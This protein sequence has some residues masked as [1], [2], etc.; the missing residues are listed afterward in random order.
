MSNFR[1]N[2]TTAEKFCK[3]VEK[4]RALGLEFDEAAETISSL[5]K[6]IAKHN[7]KKVMQEAGAIKESATNEPTAENVSADTSS[8]ITAEA[9]EVSE[10]P[11]QELNEANEA[12][13]VT[14]PKAKEAETVETTPKETNIYDEEN[15][16]AARIAKTIA[17][18][19]ALTEMGETLRKIDENKRIHAYLVAP[20]AQ[21]TYTYNHKDN[22]GEVEQKIKTGEKLYPLENIL[23]KTVFENLKKALVPLGGRLELLFMARVKGN[24]IVE[25]A[26]KVDAKAKL[27]AVYTLLENRAENIKYNAN[28]YDLETMYIL[29][30]RKGNLKSDRQL[31]AT[32]AA[33]LLENIIYCLW[34][35]LVEKGYTLGMATQ[36]PPAR[37]VEAK[38]TSA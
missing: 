29:S 32:S 25:E 9:S 26:K 4:A 12:E 8:D 36:E 1:E 28:Q 37:P 22:D 33:K 3:A 30:F 7:G 15:K 5:Q 24:R 20:Y 21:Y 35:K 31:S 6:M 16:Q 11:K 38:N 27:Q 18:E 19:K 23:D 13:P 10:T 17:E 14:E 34:S 2:E